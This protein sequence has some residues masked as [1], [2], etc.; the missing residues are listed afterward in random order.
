MDMAQFEESEIE[1]LNTVAP[2][3]LDLRA[4]AEEANRKHEEGVKESQRDNA[5]ASP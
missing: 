2:T 5:P 1:V 3:T 4:A